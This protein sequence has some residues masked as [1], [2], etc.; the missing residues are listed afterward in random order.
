MKEKQLLQERGGVY[1]AAQ[2]ERMTEDGRP[3]R[4]PYQRKKMTEDGKRW[5]CEL[6]ETNLDGCEWDLLDVPQYNL[7]EVIDKESGIALTPQQHKRIE[8]LVYEIEDLTDEQ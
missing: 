7:E 4:I 2:R 5:L 3:R 8:R 1:S 6:Y